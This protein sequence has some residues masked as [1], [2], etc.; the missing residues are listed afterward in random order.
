MVSDNNAIGIATSNSIS[1]NL[2]SKGDHG[3]ASG[4]TEQKLRSRAQSYTP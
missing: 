4:T 1:A 3:R 2:K